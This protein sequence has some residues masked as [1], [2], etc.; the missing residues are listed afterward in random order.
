ML[1]LLKQLV[2]SQKLQNQP[3]I[4]RAKLTFYLRYSLK[5][6]NRQKK[7]HSN[8]TPS[9]ITVYLFIVNHKWEF[10]EANNIP[11]RRKNTSIG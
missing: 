8:R 6:V 4:P 2:Q 11:N 9:L 5:P 7:L 1:L 10:S 3:E